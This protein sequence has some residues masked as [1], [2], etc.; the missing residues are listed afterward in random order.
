VGQT[1]FDQTGFYSAVLPTAFFT[2]F[3][4]APAAPQQLIQEV[5]EV[6]LAGEATEA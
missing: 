6:F 3:R 1:K 4:P 5:L 2:A